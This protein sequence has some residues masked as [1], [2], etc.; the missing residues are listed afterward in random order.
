MTSHSPSRMMFGQPV[1]REYVGKTRI[2]RRGIRI[3]F[4]FFSL[5]GRIGLLIVERIFNQRFQRLVMRREWTVFK[6]ARHIQPAY[7]VR[8]QRKRLRS[9]ECLN[10]MS[11]VKISGSVGRR[12]LVVIG[13]VESR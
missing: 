11:H 2:V 10:A 9:P 5:G 12:F 3:I 6:T 7:A 8:V 1:G 13:I 4:P